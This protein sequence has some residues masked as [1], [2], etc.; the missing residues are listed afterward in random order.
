MRASSRQAKNASL[1]VREEGKVTPFLFVFGE[2]A[3]LREGL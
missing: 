3:T 1:N 2:M